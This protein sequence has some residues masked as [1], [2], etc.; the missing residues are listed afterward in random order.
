MI[1][2]FTEERVRDLEAE[3]ERLSSNRNPDQDGL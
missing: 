2:T 3:L 1:T